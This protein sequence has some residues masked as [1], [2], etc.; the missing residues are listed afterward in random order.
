MLR[1]EGLAEGVRRPSPSVRGGKGTFIEQD[2]SPLSSCRC[3]TTPMEEDLAFS[4]LVEHTLTLARRWMNRKQN[5]SAIPELGRMTDFMFFE[6]DDRI[7]TKHAPMIVD[8]C[9]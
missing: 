7:I 9:R 1:L 5:T 3:A 6:V 8:C 4:Q 2:G